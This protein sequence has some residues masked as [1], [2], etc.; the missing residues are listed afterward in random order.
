MNAEK[1][2]TRS[3]H[4]LLVEMLQEN[5]DLVSA[6]PLTPHVH[7][8]VTIFE[9]TVIV[10][11]E[12]LHAGEGCRIDS[13]VKLECG[14]GMYLG[15]HVHIASFA[16]LGIGGGTLV[17]EDGS[18]F[19]SGC[20]VVTGSATP[21]GESM[22]A[23]APPEQQ[24]V[25]R[26]FVH[27][28]RNA[29]VLSG[30]IVLTRVRMGEGSIAAAGAVVTKDVRPYSIV[31]GVPAKHVAWRKHGYRQRPGDAG[32]ATP[33]DICGAMDYAAIHHTEADE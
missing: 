3:Q 27:V 9:P 16:H 15:K 19:A 29:A 8:S 31:A 32:D 28:G 24:V 26:S 33:C 10:R 12:K 5:A 4:D 7:P 2:Y 22:S 25:H 18:A 1:D 11:R 14:E 13:F 20:R 23:C 6:L 17:A 30:A 21:D